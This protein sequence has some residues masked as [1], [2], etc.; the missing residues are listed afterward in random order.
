MKYLGVVRGDWPWPLHYWKS[1]IWDVSQLVL[2]VHVPLTQ[3][4]LWQQCPSNVLMGVTER[5]HIRR[6]EKI[7]N[8]R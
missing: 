6:S 4:A 1:V 5:T 2:E 3:E 7:N 8:A